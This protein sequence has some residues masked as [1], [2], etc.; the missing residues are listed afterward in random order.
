VA[1]LLGL[2]ACGS[3][4]Q[5][6]EQANAVTDPQVEAIATDLLSAIQAEDYER[7]VG[8]YHQS[9]FDSRA[10]QAWIEELKRHRAERGPM[11]SFILRRSQADSRYSGKFF[12]FEYESVHDG[13]KRLHHLITLVQ[14][15]DADETRLVGHKITPWERTP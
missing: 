2:S 8:L 15:V 4:E 10:P 6:P 12:I 1:L 11:Q 14:P 9:F 5:T 13:N 7:A 3:G